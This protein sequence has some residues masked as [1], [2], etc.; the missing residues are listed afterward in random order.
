MT[1]VLARVDQ[2]LVH[3]VIVNAWYQYLQVNR[4]MVI[5]D[6]VSKNENMK[7]SM[8]IVKPAGTGMSIIDT[9][10]ALNNFKAGKYD[11]QRVLVLVKEPETIVKMLEAGIEIPKVNLGIIFKSDDRTQITKFIALNEKEK[12]DLNKIH[13]YGVPI[14]LQFVPNDPEKDYFDKK[15]E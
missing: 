13:E 8:R 6:E 9:E 4:F 2:R 10:K 5:D 1:V 3:G 14:K 15:G 12:A 7:T 11:N